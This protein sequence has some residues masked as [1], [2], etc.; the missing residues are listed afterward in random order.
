MAHSKRAV[1]WGTPTPATILVVQ[2]EPGPIP[3][4]TASAPAL[5][6]A[7]VAPGVATFPATISTSGKFFLSSSTDFRTCDECPCAVSITI[8]SA[9]AS[10]KAIDRSKPFWPTVDAAPTLSL[11]KESLV[12]RGFKTEFSRSFTVIKPT[13]SFCLLTIKSFS[14]RRSDRIDRA[15]SLLTGSLTTAKLV[16]V[17]ISL[18][19]VSKFSTNLISLLVRIPFKIFFSLT[20]GKPV[21]FNFF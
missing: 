7:P 9:P 6:S 8:K 15:F 10:I 4:L 16:S 11:P 19:G 20:T 3:T 13:N 12:A 1:N 21:I 5:K 14:I 17:I 18:T 2:I